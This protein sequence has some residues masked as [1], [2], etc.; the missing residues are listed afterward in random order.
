MDSLMVGGA[1]ALQCMPCK[2]K[3]NRSGDAGR[4]MPVMGAGYHTIH[5][6]TYRH[7]YG[8]YFVYMDWLFGSLVS[9]AEFAAGQEARRRGGAPAPLE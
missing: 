2:P 5:H 9:P 1:A 6:T 8:H 7:N 3:A 4:C